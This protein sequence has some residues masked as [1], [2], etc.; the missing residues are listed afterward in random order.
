M[1]NRIFDYCCKLFCFGVMVLPFGTAL[2]ATF[3]RRRGL[4]QSS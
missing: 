1:T 2:F 3:G 4:Y